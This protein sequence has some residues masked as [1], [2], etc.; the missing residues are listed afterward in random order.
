MK[1]EPQAEF[2]I[3]ASQF[4]YTFWEKH[5]ITEHPVITHIYSHVLWNAASLSYFYQTFQLKRKTG[6]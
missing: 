6:I 5:D 2:A 4:Q 1:L 3:E